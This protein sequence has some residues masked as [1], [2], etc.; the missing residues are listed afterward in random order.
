MIYLRLFLAFL[1]IG[2][3]TFGG[4]YAMIPMIEE[5]VVS[6]GWMTV[7]Q[8]VNFIA[9]SESTP[10]PFAINIST[11]VGMESGG[12]LGALC[13][14]TGVVLPSFII[15][16]VV[17]RCYVAFSGNTIVKGMLGGL[18]PVVTGLIAASALTIGRTVFAPNAVNSLSAL[19]TPVFFISLLI[20]GLSAL[21]LWK[22]RWHPILIIV[23]SAGLGIGL[24]WIKDSIA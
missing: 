16:L 8:L 18:R 20:F 13:A 14:T 17:A 22:F 21:L 3:F 11:Y 10:G 6:N 1:E 5:K 15:I 7:E 23:L 24:C 4:G 2:A 12:I 9:V 19:F